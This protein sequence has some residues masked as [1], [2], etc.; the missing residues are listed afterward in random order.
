MIISGTLQYLLYALV[1]QLRRRESLQRCEQ[2]VAAGRQQQSA[3]L[4]VSATSS[5]MQR[6]L[7]KMIHRVH[8]EGNNSSG[9]SFLTSI[10]CFL[11]QK[12]NDNS[13]ASNYHM[14]RINNASA[15]VCWPSLRVSPEPRWHHC[16]LSL[17]PCGGVSAG[18][19]KQRHNRWVRN[20]RWHHNIN[21]NNNNS[22][23]II[24]KY[25]ETHRIFLN[26]LTLS[27]GHTT[28]WLLSNRHRH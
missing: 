24:L 7:A 19:E 10:N 26:T 6:C 4:Q 28:H 1:A 17:T 5:S 20:R 21:N 14:L 11:M 15:A 12:I 9:V 2:R 8:L 13:F 25:H 18:W 23:M 27:F 3:G 16:E 22:C